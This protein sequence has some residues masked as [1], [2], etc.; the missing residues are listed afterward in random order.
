MVARNNRFCFAAPSLQENAQSINVLVGQSVTLNCVPTPDDLMVNWIIQGDVIGSSDQVS[1]SPEN[2]Q[3]VLT[4]RNVAISDSGE[5]TCYIVDFPLINRTI[6]LNVLQ[7][8]Y[9]RLN[10]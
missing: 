10:M 3:H 5:Y 8:T 7:G 6:R 1:L 2:L 9:F 4:I